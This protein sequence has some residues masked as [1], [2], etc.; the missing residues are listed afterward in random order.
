MATPSA[1]CEGKALAET[2]ILQPLP[3][4]GATVVAYLVVEEA[5][6]VP[7]VTIAAVNTPPPPSIV[8]TLRVAPL[9][10]YRVLFVSVRISPI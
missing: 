6:P 3:P 9:P 1:G 2:V 5:Y 10:V 4:D 8:K 7:A